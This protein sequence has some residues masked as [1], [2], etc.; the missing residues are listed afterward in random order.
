MNDDLASLATRAEP[1]RPETTGGEV[2]RRFEQEPDLLILPVVDEENRPV[3]M[4]DRHNFFVRMAAEFGRALYGHRP[5]SALMNN[6]PLVAEGATLVSD[7]TGEI[8]AERPSELMKGFIVVDQGRY[9][10]VGAVLS[11]L[12]ATSAANL[13]HAAEMTR[14]AERLNVATIEAQAALKAKSEFLAVMSHEIRTPL[15]GVLAIADILDRKLTQ[16]EL[17]PYVHT[18]VESGETLLRLL[19]DALDISRAE[20]GAMDLAE[21]GFSVPRMLDDLDGLW[22][23]RAEQKG[24]ALAF[25][26]RGDADQWVL[27]DEIRLKQVFNNLIGNA[28][29][30]TDRGLVE[31]SLSAERDGNHV[32][33][34]GEVRDCGPGLPADRLEMIF[35]PFVQ[36]D[37]G[38]EQGGAGLGLSI[39]REIV[40]RMD[41]EI[42]AFNNTGAGATF[43]F[44]IVLF[45]L[46]PEE[47]AEPAREAEIQVSRP[48]HVLI[49]D[50]NGANRFVAATLC[51]MFGCTSEAVEDGA[52][53]VE[54]ASSGR[55]D[56]VLMDIRMPVMDGVEATRAIRRLTGPEGAMPILALTANADP[57]DAEQYRAEGMDGVVEKPIK[58]A[59]LAAAIE[60]AVA[61]RGEQR[62]AA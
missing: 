38:R 33:L 3:G 39:C 43:R 55:F 23:A 45:D 1:V 31:V 22:R 20:S 35:N 25:S 62:Q 6:A 11:L 13:A 29:K 46:P 60:T 5:I 2:Y 14:I 26:Y 28:L 49:A 59:T 61:R 34:T 50:D 54:A 42:Q 36:T 41:G 57:W 27:G 19:T 18:I 9:L 32:L 53:A 8:L 7:F 40:R 30:F 58:T 10:G 15:N 17:K 12:Q 21:A 48:L 44:E 24:L 37:N 56:L 16:T 52:S 4:V 47:A 51:E